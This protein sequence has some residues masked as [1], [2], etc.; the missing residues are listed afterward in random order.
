VIGNNLRS[1]GIPPLG[2]ELY[3]HIEFGEEASALYPVFIVDDFIGVGV[4]YALIHEVVFVCWSV[5]IIV[6]VVVIVLEGG[7]CLWLTFLVGYFING[8]R[9]W[10]IIII[11]NI[12]ICGRRVV[13][14][15]S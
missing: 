12:V 14:C 9:P 5:V 15:P 4:G 1:D 11:S 10:H 6:V 7:L 3:S 13:Q 8:D 2:I